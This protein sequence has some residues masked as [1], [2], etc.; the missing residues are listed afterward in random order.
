M[1]SLARSAL[2]FDETIRWSTSICI[3]QSYWERSRY[4]T[5]C[6]QIRELLIFWVIVK[7]EWLRRHCLRRNNWQKMLIKVLYCMCV[8]SQYTWGCGSNTLWIII[9]CWNGWYFKILF[10]GVSLECIFSLFVMVASF[11]MGFLEY[12]TELF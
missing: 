5:S 7:R 11:W 1:I 2:D 12:K 4:N 9:R 6:N 8:S 3:Q 10:F